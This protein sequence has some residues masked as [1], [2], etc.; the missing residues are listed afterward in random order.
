MGSGKHNSSISIGKN[1]S[2][3]LEKGQWNI[4]SGC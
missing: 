4:A 2:E 1:K 3:A